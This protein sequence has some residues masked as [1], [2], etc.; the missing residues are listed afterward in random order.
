MSAIADNI[1]PTRDAPVRSAAS[2]EDYRRR[3]DEMGRIIL[4]YSDAADRMQQAQDEL[5]R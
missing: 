3:V 5:T 4:A 1:T 2:I